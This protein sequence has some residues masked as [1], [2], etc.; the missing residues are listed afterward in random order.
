MTTATDING[1]TI[2]FEAAANLMDDDIREALHSDGTDRT[3]TAFLAAY[4][5]RHEE[6]FGE[7]FAPY[8]GGAW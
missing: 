5:I 3:P 2:D 6:K 8:A 1:N 7:E 4:A